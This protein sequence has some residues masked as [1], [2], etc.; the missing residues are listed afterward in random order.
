[1]S[2][3]L[4]SDGDY[5]RRVATGDLPSITAVTMAGW[6]KVITDTQA[7]HSEQ[8]QFVLA[9]DAPNR[10][11]AMKSVGYAPNDPGNDRL[12]INWHNGT[13]DDG[14]NFT[15]DLTPAVGDWFYAAITCDGT[16]IGDLVAYW[17]NTAGVLQQ[18][19]VNDA[20]VG[21]GTMTRAEFGNFSMF[22]GLWSDAEIAYGRVWGAALSQAELEAEMFS[23]TIVRTTDIYSA[24]SG[25][26]G[27]GSDV[28]GNGRD[29]SLN[30]TVAGASEP[31]VSTSVSVNI[32]GR[33]IYILP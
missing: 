30:G 2:I 6:F 26:G 14:S 4:N 28:S 33:R 24:F 8:H 27:S 29:W 7:D 11:I 17:W 5:I 1:M 19:V 9:N 3:R 12:E 16:A 20:V 10:Y 25:A 32:P 21:T 23:P 13:V 22:S 31:P 18:S 15:T